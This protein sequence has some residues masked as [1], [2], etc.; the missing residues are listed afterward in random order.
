M[1]EVAYADWRLKGKGTDSFF[2]FEFLAAMARYVCVYVD[3]VYIVGNLSHESVVAF[4]L[5]R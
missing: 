4:A 2:S 1:E 3:A 5:L